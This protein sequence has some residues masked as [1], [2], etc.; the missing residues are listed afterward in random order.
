MKN[1][2]IISFTKKDNNWYIDFP[3]KLL[4]DEKLKVK[5]DS[6]EF[7]EMFS[8]DGKHTKIKVLLGNSSNHP[9]IDYSYF[10]ASF[11]KDS[12]DGAIYDPH[13]NGAKY[14][15]KGVFLIN[16]I[17]LSIIKE[18]PKIVWVKPLNLSNNKLYKLGLRY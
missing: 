10:Y 13:F 18:Y 1:K 16:S 11:V 5:K 2:Y 7:C 9:E 12:S 15:S 14:T 6:E 8:Y 3:N 17:V 4:D